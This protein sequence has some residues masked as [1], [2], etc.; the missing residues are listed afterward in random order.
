[1][2]SS[3]LELCFAANLQQAG[4]CFVQELRFKDAPHAWRID[5]AIP[6]AR[7]AIELEGGVWTNGRHN[8]GAGFIADCEKYNWLTEHGWRVLRYPAD[9]VYSG[10]ALE[11]VLRMLE[12]K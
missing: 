4:V 12:E 8:R 3:N 2:T 6:A 10:A 1:L 7:L 9:M 11:Q 5:F